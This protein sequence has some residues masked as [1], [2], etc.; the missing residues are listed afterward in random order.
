MYLQLENL[1]LPIYYELAQ[2]YDR[3]IEINV[4]SLLAS[5]CEQYLIMLLD[6]SVFNYGEIRCPMK[7]AL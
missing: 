7:Q 2:Y 3:V 1:M 5:I 4:R 6:G